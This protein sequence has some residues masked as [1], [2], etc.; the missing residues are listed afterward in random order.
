MAVL[1]DAAA[2]YHGKLSL[3]GIF[4]TIVTQKLP[5]VYPQCAIVLRIAFDRIEEG[6]HKLK[7]NFVNDDGKLVAPSMDMPV[8]VVFPGDATFATCN[9][10]VVFQQLKL[11][12][13]GSYS[14]DVAL[15]GRQLT[16][17]P[18]HVRLVEPKPSA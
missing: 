12:K 15:D 10:I 8:N 9:F 1:C 13:G 2:D 3:L 6:P 17:I 5:M 16:S 7:L 4:E 11:E 14:F 18:L